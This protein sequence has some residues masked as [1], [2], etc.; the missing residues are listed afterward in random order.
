MRP[1]GISAGSAR[2]VAA[3]FRGMRILNVFLLATTLSAQ[4]PARSPLRL[5]SEQFETLA[6]RADHAIV[7]IVTRGYAPASEAG[8][9]M[10]QAQRGSGSGVIVDPTGF[11]VTNAHVV[12]S[13]RR[14]QVLLPQLADRQ[15]IH[16][17]LKASAKVL[18]GTVVGLDRET[19]IAVI[20][21]E[22]SSGPLPY[23]KLGDSER[24][25]QGQLV[26][27]FGSPFGLE[28]SVTMGII[29]SVARQVRPDDPMIYIQTDASI[30]PGNSGG[31]L[32]DTDGE[33]VGINTF[34]LSRSGGNE[35]IGFAAPSNI[36]RNVYEQI[37][38]MGRVRRGQ[39]G[40]VAQTINPSLADALALPQDWGVIIAD[41]V[42]D[43]AAATAGLEVKD[44]I[45][46]LNGKVLENSRQF[47]VNIYQNA[48]QTVKLEVLR[49]KEKKEISVGVLE[50][51]RD[52]E[53]VL[54]L[55]AEDSNMVAKLG[56]LAVDLDEKVTPLIPPTRRLNGA[57]VAGIVA[58]VSSHDE[59]L[60]AGDIIYGVNNQTVHGLA[61][62]QAALKDIGRGQPV[63]LQI[64]RQ[65][66]LQFLMFQIE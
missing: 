3:S 13:M 38:Q 7:Q 54:S 31:P 24:L 35:G 9:P 12:G 51:P 29:S 26:F 66:Q 32:I 63:A 6:A 57:V 4:S 30:N 59:P 34:I 42:P 56:I 33:V 55:I 60:F 2:G 25:R 8:S 15:A 16:S 64:E 18:T 52:P 21:V 20:K 40:V 1:R 47:G 45:L 27:A 36:V 17:V 5:M 46:S 48:G 19:D 62:L 14:V 58:D 61:D 10:L 23:L 49:G 37:R 44:I 41:V 11:I 50:R 22:P 39:M 53:R 43:G 65:G 28:N